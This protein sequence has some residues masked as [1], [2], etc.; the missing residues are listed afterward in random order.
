MYAATTDQSSL[1]PLGVPAFPLANSLPP[2]DSLCAHQNLG[3]P[4]LGYTSHLL[5]PGGYGSEAGSARLFFQI[6]VYFRKMNNH[7]E[8]VQIKSPK[9]FKAKAVE[10]HEE[11]HKSSDDEY[12]EERLQKNKAESHHVVEE[13]LR[14]K[15]LLDDSY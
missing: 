12:E 4:I 10:S 2:R 1:V 5:G 7:V 9:P 8:L 6:L 14:I 3:A 11:K 13:V 15:E